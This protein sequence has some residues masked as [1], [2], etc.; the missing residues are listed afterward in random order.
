[1]KRNSNLRLLGIAAG[2]FGAVALANVA[3]AAQQH[4]HPVDR[5]A[6]HYQYRAPAYDNNNYGS[7]AYDNSAAEAAGGW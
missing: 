2:L 3:S 4:R 5:G 6:V 7:P 1:M